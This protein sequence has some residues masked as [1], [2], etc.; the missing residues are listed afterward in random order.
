MA[1]DTISRDIEVANEV[2]TTLC[3]RLVTAQLRLSPGRLRQ[4]GSAAW[5]IDADGGA[6]ETR[7][8]RWVLAA[9]AAVT[10]PETH[11][12]NTVRSWGRSAIVLA[13]GWGME[14]ELDDFES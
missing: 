1:A 9:M 11:A 8:R 2:P 4:A 5:A 12:S 14:V 10:G 3:S 7:T 6:A 13:A